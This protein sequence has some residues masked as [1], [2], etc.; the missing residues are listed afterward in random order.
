MSV[1]RM[2]PLRAQLAEAEIVEQDA[3]D[4]FTV[5]KA[6]IEIVLLAEA[7]AAA[8]KLTNEAAQKRYLTANLP[9]REGYAA[10]LVGLRTAH[11]NVLR[12]R[13]QIDTERDRRRDHEL[14]VQ[15]HLL[16]GVPRQQVRAELKLVRGERTPAFDQ[17]RHQ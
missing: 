8:V 12:L 1:D 16:Y 14:D 7:E 9:G 3:E 5:T 11:A 13:A 15:R 6:S 4:A 10:A 17:E 2:R